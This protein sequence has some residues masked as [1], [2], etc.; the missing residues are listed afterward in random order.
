M[1]GPS[2]PDIVSPRS[3]VGLEDNIVLGRDVVEALD[4]DIAIGVNWVPFHHVGVTN[5]CVL[6]QIIPQTFC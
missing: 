6:A 4:S 5:R 1:V 2:P 3:V